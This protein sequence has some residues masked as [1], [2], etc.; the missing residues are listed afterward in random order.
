MTDVIRN[1]HYTT[2]NQAQSSIRTFLQ[3]AALQTQDFSFQRPQATKPS[4]NFR[5]STTQRLRVD[6]YEDVDPVCITDPGE[7]NFDSSN[8]GTPDKKGRNKHSVYTLDSTTYAKTQTQDSPSPLP[9]TERV[10]NNEDFSSFKPVPQPYQHLSKSKKVF[11]TPFLGSFSHSLIQEISQNALY[12]VQEV[13]SKTTHATSFSQVYQIQKNE[14]KVENMRL[15]MSNIF[16]LYYKVLNL[17]KSSINYTT[18]VSKIHQ[19]LKTIETQISAEKPCDYLNKSQEHILSGAL[20]NAV[21]NEYK[22]SLQP[23]VQSAGQKL[24]KAHNE[25]YGCDYFT[26]RLDHL[27]ESFYSLTQDMNETIIVVGRAKKNIE[28]AVK[29]SDIKPKNFERFEKIKKPQQLCDEFIRIVSKMHLLKEETQILPELKSLIQKYLKALVILEIFSKD[30]EKL[31]AID[32]R[33]VKAYNTLHKKINALKLNKAQRQSFVGG[34]FIGDSQQ[35]G[36]FTAKFNILSLFEKG[37]LTEKTFAQ[38]KDFTKDMENY[39]VQIEAFC[40]NLNSEKDQNKIQQNYTEADQRIE[41]IVQVLEGIKSL[42]EFVTKSKKIVER[43]S[44]KR[45]DADLIEE[46]VRQ[47]YKNLKSQINTNNFATDF[48]TCTSALIAK[49]LDYAFDQH[50]NSSKKRKDVEKATA[51]SRTQMHAKAAQIIRRRLKL[52]NDLF[53]MSHSRIQ[54][55]ASVHDALELLK[56]KKL[57]QAFVSKES[58]VHSLQAVVKGKVTQHKIYSNKQLEGC[59]LDILRTFTV[60]VSGIPPKRT[61]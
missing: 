25:F 35:Q 9:R 28:R 56:S 29:F 1:R 8:L 3:P 53:T 37:C 38:M 39:A 13:Q 59:L 27:K 44:P 30:Q 55:S 48:N 20:E 31:M 5:R 49:S 33:L 40:A 19:L 36:S 15:K 58:Q 52:K 50:L 43:P 45:K 12:K 26:A 34:S 24:S 22:N 23:I 2:E 51:Y 4:A 10:P 16:E 47:S 60:S 42:N 6:C 61:I 57:W 32:S 7:V 46:E 21:F 14:V 17:G 18:E 11:H 54:Q 41:A